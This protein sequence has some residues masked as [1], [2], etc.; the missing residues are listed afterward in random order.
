MVEKW[1][2]H[3][4]LTFTAGEL[5][6]GGCG[7]GRGCVLRA[8]L[9]HVLLGLDVEEFLPVRILQA[10][11]AAVESL[12][13][14]I[15][16]VLQLHLSSPSD[17]SSSESPVDRHLCFGVNCPRLHC[18]ARAGWPSFTDTFCFSPGLTE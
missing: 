13:M 5:L 14:G 3:P 16:S 2:V 12:P 9:N 10:V 11:L 1:R 17:S 4:V 18:W 8:T 15:E 7:V 6:D